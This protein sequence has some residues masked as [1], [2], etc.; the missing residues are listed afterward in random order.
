MYHDV[1]VLAVDGCPD[2]LCKATR[3]VDLRAPKHALRV[4]ALS[5]PRMPR[6]GHYIQSQHQ[7]IV[8]YIM[9]YFAVVFLSRL[10]LDIEYLKLII[11]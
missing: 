11:I 5:F 7:R 6:G 1:R 4:L 9:L 8:R 2:D 3:L 10:S